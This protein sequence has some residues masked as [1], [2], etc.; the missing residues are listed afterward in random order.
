MRLLT[1]LFF[2]ATLSLILIPVVVSAVDPIIS[3]TMLSNST[4]GGGFTANRSSI[5]NSPSYEAWYAFDGTNGDN[6]W[7]SNAY[8]TA[9]SAQWVGQFIPT[10]G[11]ATSYTIYPYS[12]YSAF[13]PVTWTFEGGNSGN[14]FFPTTWTVI[15]TRSNILWTSATQRNFAVTTP[16]Q[17][18]YYRIN[19]TAPEN[20]TRAIIDELYIYGLPFTASSFT[21]NITQ[22]NATLP[23]QFTDTTAPV[24]STWNWTYTGISANNNTPKL[25]SQSQNP[26]AK[27]DGGNFSI[28][29]TTSSIIGS[30]PS[31]QITWINVTPT[32]NFTATPT[33][34]LAT[35][36]TTQFTDLTLGEPTSW[37]W[38]FG[39]GGTGTTQNP[40]HTYSS[41]GSYTVV[42]TAVFPA[43]NITKQK[44]NY[45]IAGYAPPIAAFIANNTAGDANLPIQF[46]DQS[47]G[48]ITGWNWTFGDGNQSFVQNPMF[49]Y[50]VPG[51]Y[52]V[53]LNA[54]NPLGS[55]FL[56]KTNYITV[57][58]NGY[59][60]ASFTVG[61]TAGT[62]GVLIAFTDTSNRGGNATTNYT[63]NFGDAVGT[64]PISYVNGST[65]HVYA[66]AGT[67]TPTLTLTNLMGTNTFIGP[68]ITVAIA[69]NT[70]NTNVVY[71]AQQYRFIF[72]NL[73]GTPLGGL[74][75]TVTPINFTMPANWSSQLLG[76]STQVNLTTGA[77]SGITGS[78]GSLG[79]PMITSL[80]YRVVISGV[81]S[82][83][84]L[85]NQ[86]FIEYPPSL[87]TDILVSLPTNKTPAST[88]GPVASTISYNIYNQSI[89]N[90]TNIL[91]V[92][93]Y[94]S[95]GLTNYTVVNVVN[96][97]GYT[98]NQTVYKGSSA[99]N[100]VNNFT[101]ISGTTSPA[102][103]ILSFGFSSYNPN[104]GGWNN[105]SQPL[106]LNVG[107]SMTGGSGPTTYDGWIAIILIVFISAAFTASSVYIG[108]IGI[109]LLAEFVYHI[110]QWFTPAIG[111]TAFDVMCIFW[112]CIGV[113]GY[114]TKKSKQ[115][116]F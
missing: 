15:D 48:N 56:Q 77:L 90:T 76:I 4:G 72:Q 16:G 47:T 3:N 5:F 39:D 82:S 113:I 11:I 9:G 54:T 57:Y 30:N 83:G 53:T 68:T 38:D 33:N 61:T 17:F 34:Q 31:T 109:G 75:T 86:S 12:A 89:S 71:S 106:S 97:S 58:P 64:Q 115:V 49:T 91:S 6:G 102:G 25:F 20:G 99:N 52:A 93:Y 2:I 92:N 22:G 32:V 80:N 85:V 116:V 19:I 51:V 44:T 74:Y 66:Y 65:S 60:I 41:S 87:G 84:D 107:T 7:Q 24:P 21:A 8:A 1:R 45:I 79:V 110:T 13:G 62:P 108:V 67:F 43:F 100:I 27:F 10:H 103:D 111:G 42:E 81:A 88:V 18:D 59:P 28:S 78:D 96:Q 46:T 114:T 35:P 70:A 50:R 73:L 69:Q 29:L 37:F 104:A 14:G 36:M 63:W 105:I 95:S 112:I 55:S 26:L 98:L 40:S 101:Y 94:D 23:V